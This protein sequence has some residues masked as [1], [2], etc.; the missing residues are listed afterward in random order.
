MHAW[1]IKHVGGM[2]V[3][4]TPWGGG[5]LAPNHMQPE[6]EWDDTYTSNRSLLATQSLAA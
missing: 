1:V 2:G 6:S 5:G 3:H 4:P